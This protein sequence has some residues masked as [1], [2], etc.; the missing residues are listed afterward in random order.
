MSVPSVL[1]GMAPTKPLVLPPARLAARI[2][3]AVVD[4]LF[5][6]VSGVIAIAIYLIYDDSRLPF[7]GTEYLV[8][9]LT[10]S[11]IL[12][13]LWTT[14][15]LLAKCGAT[16]G[17]AL[18]GLRVFA[19]S[20]VDDPVAGVRSKRS[21][22]WWLLRSVAGIFLWWITRGW[23]ANDSSRALHDVL[24]R[25]SVM[26]PLRRRVPERLIAYARA[27]DALV[28][29]ERNAVQRTILK[30]TSRLARKASLRW[31]E[32]LAFWSFIERYAVGVVAALA[33]LASVSGSVPIHVGQSAHPF[34]YGV[35]G[36][37]QTLRAL[38]ISFE[39]DKLISGGLGDVVALDAIPAGSSWTAIRG[40]RVGEQ[41]DVGR[42]YLA[43]RE[44]LRLLRTV[45]GD[46][47]VC[48]GANPASSVVAGVR[49]IGGVR[50]TYRL[51]LAD[52]IPSWEFFS[53]GDLGGD[54]EIGCLYVRADGG[55]VGTVHSVDS[56]S[57]SDLSVRHHTP[58]IV[59][60]DPAGNWLEPQQLASNADQVI[61]D[62]R[63]ELYAVDYSG[64][65]DVRCVVRAVD[66]QEVFCLP[67]ML[68]DETLHSWDD[69]GDWLY[70]CSTRTITGDG[71]DLY[72]VSRD[73]A[74]I[75]WVL[76]G[77]VSPDEVVLDPVAD[78]SDSL[79]G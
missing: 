65:R 34:E 30:L 42:L 35:L 7:Q 72:R 69:S 60:F 6:M 54:L 36:K 22:W 31:L 25:T 26:Q 16:F 27:L 59:A 67:S 66:L 58:W 24:F 5:V 40:H 46:G 62:P 47:L 28:D 55:L 75:E 71:C 10:T 1:T 4:L 17:H 41:V 51:D 21:A 74:R 78:Y 44:T 15:I 52:G 53:G 2:G 38:S 13:T 77:Q 73:G 56:R 19:G 18:F 43:D 45:A 23:W 68:Y 79:D 37:P 29:A 70:F 50:T 64:V 49:E 14:T 63:N 32:V 61:P 33:I 11:T 39:E 12:V 57:G 8:V 48:V 9:V 20:Q 3:A 76:N